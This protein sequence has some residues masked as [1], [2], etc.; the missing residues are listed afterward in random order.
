MNIFSSQ[1][2]PLQ[3]LIIISWVVFFLFAIDALQRRRF[4]WLHF[5]VFFWWISIIILFALNIWLLN[6][7][8]S[9][10]WV[11][12]WADLLVYVSIILLAYF[13]FEILNKVTRQSFLT[14]R[15]ISEQAI[16]NYISNQD[17]NNFELK[18]DK[19]SNYLFLIRAYNEWTTL[20]WV[21]DEIVEKGFSKILVVNDW[22]ID[23]SSCV[24]QDKQK[25]HKKSLIILL[26]HLINR[27]WW[28]ANKTGFEFLKKYWDVLNIKWI[29][30]Y[31]A[32]WQMN[33]ADISNFI[34]FID[35]DKSIDILLWTRFIEW[36]KALNIPKLRRLVLAWSKIVTYVFNWLWVTDPH[37]WY[38]VI[39]LDSIRKMKIVSDW[40]IYASELLE[41]V[42]RLSLNYKEVPVNII[43]TEYSLNKW[44]KNWN[45]IKIFL[46]LIYNKFFYK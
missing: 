6:K 44:Q 19:Y 38:R 46:W 29:V 30:T 4:N 41:E 10:F 25:Q 18:K 2:T 37:N 28:A 43:Y 5:L 23:N 32:D 22:S 1:F 7:L 34:K 45:A 13:Y 21:I 26:N 27:W 20:P 15:I 31:D 3:A 24:V 42:Y 16:T 40:M 39:S 14:T 33:I 9:F 12:R 36:W 17:I 11:N 35:S 8:G